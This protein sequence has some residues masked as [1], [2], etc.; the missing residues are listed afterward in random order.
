MYC[1]LTRD[2]NRQSSSLL[3]SLIASWR[4]SW[5]FFSTA[6]LHRRDSERDIIV[7]EISSHARCSMPECLVAP[8]SSTTHPRRSPAMSFLLRCWSQ[9]SCIVVYIGSSGLPPCQTI[10]IIQA[11]ERNLQHKEQLPFSTLLFHALCNFA[12]LKFSR[13]V[14]CGCHHAISSSSPMLKKEI[15]T[16]KKQFSFLLCCCLM[17]CIYLLI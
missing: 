4:S 9:I 12:H 15:A 14:A 7:G 10:N 3:T 2:G 13:I 6:A 17:H 11:Q 1:D 5:C 16:T 8:F